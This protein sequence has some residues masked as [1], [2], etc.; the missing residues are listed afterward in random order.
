MANIIAENVQRLMREK[1]LSGRRLAELSGQNPMTINNLINGR[2]MPGADVVFDVADALE[3][4]VD[5]LRE[6]VVKKS[7]KSA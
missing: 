1:K 6:A 7:R 5:A 3:V 4:T 2:H